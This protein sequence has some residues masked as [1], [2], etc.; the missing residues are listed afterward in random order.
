MTNIYRSHKCGEL[1]QA[2]AGKTVTLSGWIHRKRDH[3]QLLFIDLRD[4][5]GLTQCVIEKEGT[6]FKEVE[7]IRVE[8]VVK[9]TGKV[10]ARPEDMI[11][12]ELATG[13]I[14]VQIENFEILSVADVV[15]LQVNQDSDA[16]EELRLKYR[17]LDLRR[18][19]VHKNIMLRSHVIASL[20]NRMRSQGFNEFQ[21]PI[22]TASSPEGARD[23]LVPSRVHPGKFY[24]LPQAPQ[25]F[26]QLLMMSGFDRYFQVAPCFRD[27]DGRADRTP[28]E[29][30]Q[31]DLEMSFVTQDDVFGAIEPV[32]QGIFEEFADFTG[33]KKRVSS[34]PFVHISYDESMLKYG[35]DK[36]DL[37]NP[38]FIA[39]VANLFASSKIEFNAFKEIL[40]NKG[41]IRAI[42]VPHGD[43]Q[44]R[45]FYDKLDSWAKEQGAK[46]LAYIILMPNNTVKGTLSKFITPEVAQEFAALT[47]AKTG[48]AI[49]FVAG[50]KDHTVKLAGELRTKLGNDLNLIDK[51][52]FKFCWIVDFPMFEYNEDLQ[53]VDFSHNPF[54]MVQGGLKALNE[55][56]PLTLKAHQYDLVCNGYEMASGAIRN[57]L[58]EVMFKA[59]A[60]A[61][62]TKDEVETKFGGMLSAFHYGAPPHGG[63]ALG[64]DRI[65]MLLSDEPNLREVIA[66]P[67]TQKGEDLMMGAPSTVTEKQLRE[68]HIQ[69]RNKDK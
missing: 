25:Q 53:K 61:G 56:D 68:V 66:F 28:G 27:E 59:F 63:A 40:A 67:M 24:A 42:A 29:F 52:Q 16:S 46:G 47:G 17:F 69:L 54:S 34:A 43:T 26:K 15:P 18:E 11:N 35:C 45:S 32:A 36:P 22:L 20:R 9:I 13:E 49:F 31:L 51:N 10:L 38:L 8:S 4:H 23:F 7:N 50:G 19:K 1:R 57:H 39:D 55:Q 5:Y 21:T 60:I 2:D 14:E 48:D 62:Y 65:I 3:G 41:V 64:I 12:H 6:V 58:P 30:Y 44:P 33:V 37:R